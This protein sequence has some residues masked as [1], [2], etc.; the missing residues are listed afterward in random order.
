MDLV[1]ESNL[2]HRLE[3]VL[4]HHNAIRKGLGKKIYEKNQLRNDL[5]KIAPKILNFLN[6]FGKN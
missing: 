1:S 4:D 5:L 6:Q 3:T 2:D